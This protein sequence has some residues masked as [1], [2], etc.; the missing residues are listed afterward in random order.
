MTARPEYFLMSIVNHHHCTRGSW[1]W[2]EEASS[3]TKVQHRKAFPG[4]AWRALYT[5]ALC[6]FH[7]EAGSMI[8]EHLTTFVLTLLHM[9]ILVWLSATDLH[10]G[11]TASTYLAYLSVFQ[12]RV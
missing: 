9:Y 2:D 7:R 8:Y 5:I 11:A 4:M 12:F 3:Y 6:A 1:D 10:P